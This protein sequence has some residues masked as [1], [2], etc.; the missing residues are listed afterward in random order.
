MI[1]SDDRGL[2][3]DYFQKLFSQ[4]EDKNLAVTWSGGADSTFTF[5]YMAKL[6]H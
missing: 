1:L 2:E 3:V 6:M 5:W 4:V